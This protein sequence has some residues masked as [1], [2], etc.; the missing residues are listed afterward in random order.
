MEALDKINFKKYGSDTSSRTI[1]FIHGACTSSEIWNDVVR[2][3]EWNNQYNLITIDLPGH[4][5]SFKSRDPDNDYMLKGMG[6]QLAKFIN[7]DLQ[8][9]SYV[10][11]GNS[12]GTNII[13]EA[14]RSLSCCTGIFLIGVSIAGGEIGLA[15][16]AQP[17]QNMATLFSHSPNDEEIALFIGDIIYNKSPN[18]KK[19]FILMFNDTDPAF[20]VTM[21]NCVMA[22]AWTDEIDVLEKQLFSVAVV[23]VKMKN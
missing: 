13:A 6:V 4:G 1:V 8:L 12:I 21:G 9:P 10:L 14:L 18:L 3:S 19:K 2:N 16:I 17:N 20:R 11:V 15:T 23:L 7:E 5:E 22:A